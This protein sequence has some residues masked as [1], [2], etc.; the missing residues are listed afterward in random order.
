MNK[1]KHIS[2]AARRKIA[3][4]SKL[5]GTALRPRLSVTRTNEHLSLQAIDDQAARTVAASSD[6]KVKT[7]GTKTERAAAV[8]KDL[9]KIL[10]EKKVT[11]L[12][13]DRGCYRYH[14]RVKT[15]AETLR[16]VG[17]KV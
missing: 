13:F 4:S 8:A 10:A 15:V 2:T 11:Q 3:V 12:V 6:L 17:I 16:E 1:V 7:K 5:H 9:A 14:G